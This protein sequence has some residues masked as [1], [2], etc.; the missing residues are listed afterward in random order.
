MT[1]IANGCHEQIFMTV[2]IAEK[3]TSSNNGN[4]TSMT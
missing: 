1:T 2:Q 3:L 4:N